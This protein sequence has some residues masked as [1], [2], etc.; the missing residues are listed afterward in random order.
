MFYTERK[1]PL[2]GY[3]FRIKIDGIS[4]GGFRSIRGVGVDIKTF[5]YK[6]GGNN[7]GNLSFFNGLEWKGVSLEKG[8][9]STASIFWG[10]LSALL[11]REF[12]KV[13]SVMGKQIRLPWKRGMRI[14][15]LG[16]GDEKVMI[17]LY[18]VI[19][20]GVEF[21]ELNAES[22]NVWVERAN[23]KFRGMMVNGLVNKAV[24]MIT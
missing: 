11:I 19:I 2:K 10:W 12:G 14:E 13:V 1:D 9:F 15:V 16:R 20:V 5:D 22:S 18:D 24:G 21:G 23:L 6:E 17:D 8:M 4:V 3:R 7:V